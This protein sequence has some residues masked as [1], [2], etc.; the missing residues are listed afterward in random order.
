MA[1]ANLR[2]ILEHLQGAS[3]D[4][5]ERFLPRNVNKPP[6]TMQSNGDSY[7]HVEA[8]GYVLNLPSG[9]CMPMFHTTYGA[10]DSV[11]SFSVSGEPKCIDGGLLFT[12]AR[13][14]TM[15]HLVKHGPHKRVASIVRTDDT[16][17]YTQ[18]LNAD[19]IPIHIVTTTGDTQLDEHFQ[20][21]A[22]VKTITTTPTH[23]ITKE[24]GKEPIKVSYLHPKLHM[25]TQGGSMK[26]MLVDVCVSFVGSCRKRSIIYDLQSATVTCE[27]RALPGK[28]VIANGQ[29][30]FHG[31]FFVHYFAIADGKVTYTGAKGTSA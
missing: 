18:K 8:V 3:P 12:D 28:L 27:G 25:I 10:I 29:L 24:T 17:A 1:E 30:A 16:T 31:A 15:V 13:W 23:Q 11:R 4:E 5:I 22:M 26:Y 21:G 9:R 6:P 19:Y 20:C 14:Q 7:L 2:I